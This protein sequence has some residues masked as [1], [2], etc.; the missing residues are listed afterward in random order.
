[1]RPRRWLGVASAALIIATACAGGGASPAAS[2]PAGA[3]TMAAS[4]A[5]GAPTMAASP[6]TGAPTEA[7]SP[8]G[9]PAPTSPSA[10]AEA[11][12]LRFATYVWQPATVEATEQIVADWNEANPNIQ[13]EIVPI[14]VNTVHDALVTQ[15]QGGTAADIVHNEAG[16]LAGFVNQGFLA[17]MTPLI[18]EELMSDAP[19]GIW[20]SITYDDKIYAAPLLLQSYVVFANAA[21]LEEAG[22]EQPTIDSPWTWDDLQANARTLTSG[23]RFGLAWGLKSPVAAILSTALNFDGQF[24]YDEGGTTVVRVGEGEREILSRVHEMTYT[25]NAIDPATLGASG[26]DNLAAFLAGRFSMFIG[27][28]FYGQQLIDQA[29][30]DFDWVMLPL[31]QGETQ[32]Q[33]ANPQTLSIATQSEHP[34]E[35]M[36]FITFFT[37]PENLSRLA[38]GDW[39]V[40]ATTSAG[41]AVLEETGGENGWDVVVSSTEH[42]SVAPFLKLEDFPQWRDQIATPGMQQY[43]ANQ[44]DLDTLGR[45]LEEGWAQISGG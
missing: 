5:T 26:S 34:E 2:P 37:Q 8:G 31:L 3:P 24:F 28:N 42:L 44:I 38:M 27:G 20:D 6:A 25:D 19:Q 4:P 11:V 33:N 21:H 12:D 29:P 36:Q 7:A 30:E 9:S 13:V 39:L 23:D 14:D 22:I 18:P 15:F 41:E 16:D 35:A 10:P 32:T 43:F 40:P 1:M 17:D 45:Q